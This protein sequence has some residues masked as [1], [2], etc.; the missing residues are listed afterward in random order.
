MRREVTAEEGTGDARETEDG[1][2]DPLIASAI[3]RRDDVAD[4][5]LCRDGEPA[6]A[7]TLDGAEGDQLAHVPAHTTERRADEEE[8]DRA[9]QD[10]FAP[11]HVAQLSIERCH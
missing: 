3:A 11:I 1:A 5:G 9:L 8:N 4:D 2:E 6:T 10:P 7:K